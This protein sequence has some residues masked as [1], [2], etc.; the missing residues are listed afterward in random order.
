M[1]KSLLFI[2]FLAFF[3]Q[4]AYGLSKVMLFFAFRPELKT[5]FD[6]LLFSQLHIGIYYESLCPDSIRFIK[7]QLEPEYRNF[8]DFVDIE[9]IPFGKSVVTL[10][11]FHCKIQVGANGV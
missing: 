6:C 3:T 9:F 4:S 11:R 7:N 8:A 10:L 2:S 5:S 1:T